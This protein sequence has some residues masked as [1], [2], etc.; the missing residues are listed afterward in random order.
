MVI[1]EVRSYMTRCTRIFSTI[2]YAT[3][4]AVALPA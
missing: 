3:F 4:L 2:A 1:Q